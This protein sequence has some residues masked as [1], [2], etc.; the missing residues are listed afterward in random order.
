M[1]N[2]PGA[3]SKHAPGAYLEIHNAP[4]ACLNMLLEQCT[5]K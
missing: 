3:Y 5:S 2:A 1:H 4:G